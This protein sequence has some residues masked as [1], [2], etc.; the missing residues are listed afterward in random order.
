MDHHHLFDPSL[1]LEQAHTIPSRWYFDPEIAAAA[2]RAV[3]GAT[4]QLVAHLDQVSEPG[5]FCTADIAGEPILIVR[6]TDSVLRA[7]YNVCR[8]RAALL[9]TEPQ[10]KVSRLRCRYHGWTYDLAGRLRGT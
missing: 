4:W 1:P 8:H 7:F 9:L 6:D 5:S 2:R 3:F 10:G